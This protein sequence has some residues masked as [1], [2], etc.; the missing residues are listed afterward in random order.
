L[1]KT[2]DHNIDND[3]FYEKE[4]EI[5]YHIWNKLLHFRPLSIFT[6]DRN[7]LLLSFWLIRSSQ[8]LFWIKF[9]T[10]YM[11]DFRSALTLN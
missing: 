8:Q 11:Y 4:D 6:W 5:F 7:L 2:L 3:V 10:I 9:I 1:H